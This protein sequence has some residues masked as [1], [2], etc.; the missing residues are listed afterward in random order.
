MFGR[1]PLKPAFFTN[2]TVDSHNEQ[3]IELTLILLKYS[4]RHFRA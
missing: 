2:E 4:N 3:Q 1:F